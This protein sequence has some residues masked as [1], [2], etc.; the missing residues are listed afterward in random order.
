MTLLN[1]FKRLLPQPAGGSVA[2]ATPEGEPNV[3]EKALFLRIEDFLLTSKLY[4]DENINRNTLANQLQSN[5]NY[6]AKA[7]RRNL[8]M[9]FNEYINSLRV[10]YA[11]DLLSDSAN[12]TGIVKI[13]AECGF[14]NRISFYRCFMAIHGIS[15]TEYR[16]KNKK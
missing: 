15:P 16:N 10:A 8:Q 5:E 12:N 1:Y 14:K 4:L 2:A 7:I 13:A 11:C 3:A 6:V 9:T